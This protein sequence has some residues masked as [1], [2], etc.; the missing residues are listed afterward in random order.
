[1]S[2]KTTWFQTTLMTLIYSILY[3]IFELNVIYRNARLFRYTGEVYNWSFMFS[4]IIILHI[5]CFCKVLEFNLLVMNLLLF[6][7]IE[8]ASFWICGAL[9]DQS[10]AFPVGNWFDTTFSI[11][12]VFGLGTPL[13]IFP[14]VPLFY[15][16]GLALRI[17]YDIL[18]LYYRKTIITSIY[19]NCCV[20]ILLAFLGSSII[21]T[22]CGLF[23][24]LP[25]NVG[26]HTFIPCNEINKPFVISIFGCMVII[27]FILTIT[28]NKLCLRFR[29][30]RVENH[31]V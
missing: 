21:F 24:K 26:T 20:A 15:I 17:I 16:Y 5:I 14:Y 9:I 10:S 7:I 22:P 1:M 8:D 29:S 30:V 28:I 11:F 19:S 31:I 23:S 4:V 25:S 13:K 3:G 2:H 12:Y 27:F 6:A 18:Y